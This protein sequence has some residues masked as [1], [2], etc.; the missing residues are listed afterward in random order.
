MAML[1]QRYKT[2]QNY[3][4]QNEIYAFK[5]IDFNFENIKTHFLMLVKMCLS[6]EALCLFILYVM[7]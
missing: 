1:F 5:N 3:D 6:F 4:S 2:L 7:P